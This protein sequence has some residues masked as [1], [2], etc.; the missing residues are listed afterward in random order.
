MNENNGI[1]NEE[2]GTCWN[3]LHDIDEL[4]RNT[5]FAL[6]ENDMERVRKQIRQ[7][8]AR[9]NDD[10]VPVK[11]VIT[12]RMNAGK[13][14]MADV[15]FFGGKGVLNSEATP[16]TA[17][18]TYIRC[19]NERHRE[20]CAIVHF[21]RR[22]DVEQMENYISKQSEDGKSD[23]AGAIAD[24]IRFQET[25]QLLSKINADPAKRDLLLDTEK[26]IKRDELRKY[27]DVEGE[28]SDYVSYIEVYID[29]VRLKDLEIVD[30]P[31]LG[32]PVASRSEKARDESR[33]AEV[34][35]YLSCARH[36]MNMEDA[37]E[38]ARLKRAGCKN[39]V[40][41]MS[42][43]DEVF[44][45]EDEEEELSDLKDTFI[46]DQIADEGK[47]RIKDAMKRNGVEY[48]P[49]EI[50]PICALGAKLSRHTLEEDDSYYRNKVS[51][52]FPDLSDYDAVDEL[53]GI[54]N[55]QKERERVTK[56]KESIR[57][58]FN[59]EMLRKCQI[60]V[61]NVYQ[62][63]LERIKN[64]IAMKEA[65][66]KNPEDAVEAEKA[67]GEWERL[68]YSEIRKALGE[69]CTEIDQE[70]ENIKKELYSHAS[71]AR[72]NMDD[73]KSPDSLN[74][75]YEYTFRNAVDDMFSNGIEGRLSFEDGSK[76][77]GQM[78]ERF[79]NTLHKS[80]VPEKIAATR[81]LTGRVYGILQNTFEAE[82][83][84]KYRG[85]LRNALP[86][87][88][89]KDILNDN[90]E[91]V[92]LHSPG[93]KYK[94]NPWKKRAKKNASAVAK[95][96]EAVDKAVGSINS[97]VDYYSS[98]NIRTLFETIQDKLRSDASSEID[99][100]K[101]EL[102]QRNTKA[103]ED[104]IEECRTWL[105]ELEKLDCAE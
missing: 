35:F 12:G 4:F 88:N 87:N 14:M 69:I 26:K 47:E 82:I 55:L 45:P 34:V 105:E 67:L 15:L 29:D 22:D 76:T 17:N 81:G 49:V 98:N 27:S 51:K 84:A 96:K 79:K 56:E 86:E 33:T 104:Q 78:F 24:K 13:S 89:I 80:H 3:R 99:T 7:T 90:Y 40:L 44:E 57:E 63:L 5:R 94:S 41:I 50:I 42:Q 37:D 66:L 9:I 23:D 72:K 95:C 85:V 59:K 38:F 28:F 70:C 8:D 11:I 93:F 30:T 6:D 71:S 16:A 91:T 48:E 64:D 25:E 46:Y 10:S 60:E 52:L 77:Y 53:S 68:L 74:G 73:A 18:I 2:L 83:H 43:F 92:L 58:D 101:E 20:E 39:I 100:V 62:S 102:R 36:F 97:S 1:K 65:I 75:A 19:T 21:L 31:G 32:D 61:E 54:H 103:L